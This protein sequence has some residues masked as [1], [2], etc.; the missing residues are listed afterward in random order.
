MTT[1]QKLETVADAEIELRRTVLLDN[2]NNLRFLR[3]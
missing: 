2:D 1:P 3:V